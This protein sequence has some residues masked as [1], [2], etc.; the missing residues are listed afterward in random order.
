MVHLP[1]VQTIWQK[2]PDVVRP[3][4][5][6]VSHFQDSTFFIHIPQTSIC[7]RTCSKDQFFCDKRK[8]KLLN[9]ASMMRDGGKRNKLYSYSDIDFKTISMPKVKLEPFLPKICFNRVTNSV[10]IMNPKF[11]IKLK[12]P[13]VHEI[14]W[15]LEYFEIHIPQTT[16]YQIFNGPQ[17][18]LVKVFH[19]TIAVSFENF[20]LS[21]FMII[22]V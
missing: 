18:N 20:K 19:N 1:L 8:F 12:Q 11:F 2:N 3:R 14:I 9:I 16:H 21:K 4:P 6:F 22:N 15:K 17:I 10:N 7:L 5:S 13:Y